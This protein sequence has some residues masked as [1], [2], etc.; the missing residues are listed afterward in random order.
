MY[1]PGFVLPVKAVGTAKQPEISKLPK[2]PKMS[3]L[4]KQPEMSTLPKQPEMS[5]LAKQ[6]E[7]ST[8]LMYLWFEYKLLIY[9]SIY[10]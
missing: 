2:Q 5:T 10:I 4:P 6:S 1:A 9:T 8:T 3:K 7:M